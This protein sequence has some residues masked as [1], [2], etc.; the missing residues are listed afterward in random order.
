[1]PSSLKQNLT[2]NYLDAARRM[3][4]RTKRRC[5]TAY[6]E[7]Y[8][9]IAFWRSLLAEFEDDTLY[10]RVML[11]SSRSLAKGK[12]TVLLNSLEAKQLGRSLIACVDS[13]YDF[14]LQGATRLSHDINS[15]PYIFQ[16][17]GYAIENY[18]CY[19][20]SLHEVCVQATLN[21]KYTIDFPDFLS[22]YSVIVYPLFIWN[23]YFYK[24]GD[25]NTFPMHEL[26][27]CTRIGD[28][29]SRQPEQSLKAVQQRV[30]RKLNSLRRRHAKQ[31][32]KVDQLAE[33]LTRLDL[34]PERTYLYMQGHHVMDNVVLPI[35]NP[36]C[37]RL[38]RERE[39]E[40]RRLAMHK[41]QRENE[42]SGYENSASPVATVLKHN[43][44]YK[45]LNLYQWMRQDVEEFTRE[46]KKET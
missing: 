31:Q 38:R 41:E 1:M 26:S 19:A 43:E 44:G 4:P 12:K 11:P 10:F 14:L 34:T 20:E 3:S 25:T 37:T 13:D 5:V 9:D 8:D 17:Y 32:A 23:V 45:N 42:L 18:H 15:N 33:E 6:V 7:S 22:R 36:I 16:T 39:D 27:E 35:L 28:F 29:D 2:S 40:I 24:I 21:D 46:V 30:N